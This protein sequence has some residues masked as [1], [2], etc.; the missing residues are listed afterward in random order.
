MTVTEV[1]IPKRVFDINQAHNAVQMHPVC[2]TES[3]HDY[4]LDEMK[5][6]NTQLNMREK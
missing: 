1:K 4:I 3:D 2:L 5:N 6:L